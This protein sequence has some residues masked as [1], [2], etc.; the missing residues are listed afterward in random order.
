MAKI[1]GIGG[2][3]FRAK[4]PKA[5]RT[6][7][8]KHLGIGTLPN[9]PWGADDDA[10]LIVWRDNNDQDKTCYT[11]LEMFPDDDS[12]FFGS[13]SQEM[14]LNF[15]VDDLEGAIKDMQAAGAEKVGDVMTIQSGRLARFKDPEGKLFELW[16]PKAGF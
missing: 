3:F 14:L 11:V 4:D 2:I 10:A 1:Q 12:E 16:E 5:M 13:S 6:W 7:Y 15:R 9:S 8:E